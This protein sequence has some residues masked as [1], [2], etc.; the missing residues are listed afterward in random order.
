[1]AWLEAP[2]RSLLRPLLGVC[3]AAALF[4]VIGYL[5]GGPLDRPWQLTTL[6]VGTGAILA[7]AAYA[8]PAESPEWP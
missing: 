2:D 7:A 4:G 5:A 1:M 6:G 3:L 8:Y